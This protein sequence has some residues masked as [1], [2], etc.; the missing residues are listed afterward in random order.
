MTTRHRVLVCGGRDFNDRAYLFAVLDHYITQTGGFECVI[1]GAARG[2]DTLAGEWADERGVRGLP[3][4]ADW[5]ANGRAAGPIRNA[6][7]LRE[8]RPSVVVAFPGG[9]G[10]DDMIQ[11]SERAGVPVIRV[12]PRC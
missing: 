3:F 11:R 5:E 6:R 4:P 1:Q 10:T 8:G 2:A 9:R 12:P 7:M